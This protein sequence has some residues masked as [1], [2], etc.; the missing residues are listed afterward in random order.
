M[1]ERVVGV[2]VVAQCERCSD[3]KM[4]DPL[5]NDIDRCSDREI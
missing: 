3:R 2:I 1:I 4:H 5:L